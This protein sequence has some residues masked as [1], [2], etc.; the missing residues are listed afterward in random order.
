[1]H[2]AP[3]RFFFPFLK[4]LPPS[5]LNIS[6]RA[7]WHHCCSMASHTETL[8]SSGTSMKSS[9]TFPW[10]CSNCLLPT[11]WY[12]LVGW[13]TTGM[14]SRGGTLGL[15]LDHMYIF[16]LLLL[17]VTFAVAVGATSALTVNRYLKSTFSFMGTSCQTLLLVLCVWVKDLVLV[18][19]SG[20]ATNILQQVVGFKF[21][22]MGADPKRKM[23][24][25]HCF[26]HLLELHDQSWRWWHMYCKKN[27]S[28]FA[29]I[30]WQW[31]QKCAF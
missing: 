22:K 5:E 13:M 30:M 26:F 1:M 2:Q 29:L 6:Y 3:Q 20:V 7:T 8:C 21:W 28:T 11:T 25:K 16:V 14:C 18:G 9:G 17:L 27:Q 10:L 24:K 23:V 19:V 31:Y 4:E 12:H 15:C